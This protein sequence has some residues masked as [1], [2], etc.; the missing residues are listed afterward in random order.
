MKRRGFLKRTGAAFVA[1]GL[2]SPSAHAAPGPSSLMW[3]RLKERQLS[4]TARVVSYEGARPVHSVDVVLDGGRTARADIDGTSWT[5]TARATPVREQPDAIDLQLRFKLARGKVQQVRVALAL[6]VAGWSKDNYVLLPGACYRGNRFESRHISYPPLLTEPADIG[7]NVPTIIP[8]LPRLNLRAGPSQLQLLASDLTT[9]AV[10]FQ[11]PRERSGVWIL[12]DPTTSLGVS[13]IAVEE[14]DDRAQATF[15][16]TA[17]GLR[18]DPGNRGAGARLPA[19]ERGA[20][21]KTGAEV[22]LRG[23][24]YLFAC[25]DVQGLFERFVG[26][27]KDLSG[28]TRLRH[29]LPL[30]AAWKIH[31]ARANQESWSDKGGYY[32]AGARDT[33]YTDWQT[34]WCGGIITTL[35]LLLA[36]D[37]AT[38]ER[39]F[40]TFDFLFGGGQARSGFFRA[41]SDGETWFDDAF[42]ARGPS[43]KDAGPGAGKAPLYRHAKKWHLVR[44]SADVL[45]FM[46]KQLLL[47]EKQEPPLKAKSAWSKGLGRCADAF[48]RLWDRN[49]Q[50][51]QFLNV[52]TGDIVVG[53]S[54][55]GAIAPAG[56]A[57]ASQVFKKPD[58][59]RVA[60]ETGQYFY[61]KFT[62][63]G[64]TTGGP[65]D[66][67]QCP[68]SESASGLL[69]SFVVLYEVT[70]DRVWA[71]RGAEMAQQLTSWIVS[72]DFP[73]RTHASAASSGGELQTTGALFTNA[74]SRGGSPGFVAQSGDALFKL[75][76]ATGTT[77][78][79]ELL[80]DTAHNLT[81]YTAPL[82][83]PGGRAPEAPGAALA[84]HRV[85]SSAWLGAGGEVIPA[86]V[87]LQTCS[88]LTYAEVPGLYVQ[89]DRAFLFPIDHVTA[90]V[91]EKTATQLIVTVRNPTKVEAAVRVFAESSADMARPLGVGTLAGA[92]TVTIPGGEERDVTFPRG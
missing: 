63:V 47:M 13:G 87:P 26:L 67:L 77:E 33:P 86:S 41:M 74:Q 46:S 78:F 49:R 59:L 43:E 17:P 80:R 51:G 28:P 68:D 34:G 64:L 30:S 24:V 8:E 65:P 62:R 50:L 21:L 45:Y 18:H 40:R 7:P 91:K 75:Y 85:D 58:Y 29:E 38:R 69:E 22:L 39:V 16:V 6:T 2:T 92:Q 31:E 37:A 15:L 1:G 19:G 27:R 32:G 61:D 12:T 82:D 53:G 9:P 10:G 66:A 83:G 48:V 42:L 76:R 57:L 84:V 35:P 54:A 89:P 72:Y 81:Q 55:A 11:S 3:A 25:H 90:V 73:R 60:Q 70:G 5:I 52:E 14:T 4:V 56:L 71:E 20:D 79:L 88:L 23:R 44:R 36:G